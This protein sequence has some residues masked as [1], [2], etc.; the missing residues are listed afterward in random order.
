MLPK[1]LLLLLRY[2]RRLWVRVSLI[3]LLSVI[4]AVLAPTL[5]PYLPDKAV[6]WFSRDA[7]MP[8][9]TIL[10]SGMLAV[11]TFSLNVMVSAYRNAAGQATP[12]AYRY[13]LQ[14][15]T[16]QTVLATFVGAFIY[17]LVAIILFRAQIYDEASS[18]IVFATTVLVVVLIIFAILR[19][20]DHLSNLGSM[21][22]TLYLVEKRAGVVLRARQRAPA[23]GA[24]VLTD[25]APD[26]AGAHALKSPA[27]GYVQYIDI[28]GLQS[29]L[30]EHDAQL[31]LRTQPGKFVQAG[32]PLADVAGVS[33]D[34]A[35]ALHSFFTVAPER[36]FEQ[37][38]TFAVTVLS[39][40]GSRALSP[41]VNDPGTA[42]DV[43]R[44]LQR[45]LW[46]FGGLEDEEKRIKANNACDRVHARPVAARDLV[47]DAFAPLA[48]DGAGM[49]EVTLQLAA[50]LAELAQHP[51]QDLASACREMAQYL[52]DHADKAMVLDQDRDRLRQITCDPET[53]ESV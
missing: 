53:A 35:Q 10:A 24:R 2:S 8:V 17:S 44:R 7:V 19:W 12:R 1:Y 15:T 28:P 16:T 32:Q 3:S 37:D 45:L 34:M 14:D 26:M 52:Q 49:I 25:S 47:I 36:S 39:E 11:T 51:D 6:E 5:A 30:N 43:I 13:L 29:K 31:C 50:A 21:D 4:A 23:F 38:S 41:G 33:S 42:I 46:D 48:R 20:I 22:H 9:L 27:T 40:I 18:V